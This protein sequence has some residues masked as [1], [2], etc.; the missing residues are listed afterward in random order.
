MSL[1]PRRLFGTNGIRGVT[2]VDM[3]PDF[4]TRIAYAIGTYFG[5]GEIVVGYDAR[6]SSFL[7]SRAVI[8]GLLA[9]GCSVYEIGRVP[10]PCLQFYVRSQ[11][12]DGGVMITASH[13]PPQYNGIKVVA[14]DGV[15]IDRTEEVKVEEIYFNQRWRLA[16]WDRIPR[17][18]VC[19]DAIDVYI[20]GIL[21]HVD[22]EAI[23][24]AKLT[25]I[26]DPGGGVGA[27][28]TPRLLSELGCRV[29]TI[30]ANLDPLFS[31]RGPEPRP[32][33]LDGLRSTVITSKAAFGVAHDGDADRAIFA[34]DKGR[35][36]WGDRSFAVIEN[37][38]LDKHPG[39]TVVTPVSSSRVIEDVAQR[40]GSQVYWVRVGS[41][42]VSRTMT[43][44]NFMIGGEENGGVFY[45][46]HQPVRDGALAAALIAHIIVESGKT[47]AQL[48]DDLP[49]YHQIKEKVHAP[50]EKADK[51]V[52]LAQREL[53]AIR[54]DTVDGVKAWFEDGSWLLIRPSGTEPIFRIFSEARTPERARELADL[55]KS[56]VLQA[57]HA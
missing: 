1:P 57:T 52:E 43:K 45:G 47:L 23:R 17:H 12:F 27:L 15:E 24:E 36:H 37:W 44:H 29:M 54:F 13:N 18:Y 14:S 49:Q 9:S 32:D 50:R 33:V 20:N 41:V 51:V 30:N 11:N 19:E 25:V 4:A 8:A 46:P 6:S 42:D 7:L 5:G 56:I 40:H 31:A 38:F 48:L 53:T 26:V 2:N 34:D 3:T 28:T 39:E 10:T 22:A 16:N 55:G 35:V 21:R